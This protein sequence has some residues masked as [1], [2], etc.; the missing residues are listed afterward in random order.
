MWKKIRIS[1]LL[2]ILLVVLVNNWR[3]QNQNWNRPIVVLLHP[4]NADG[5]LSTGQYIQHLQPSQFE[6]VKTYLEQQSAA[7]RQPI[8]VI[9]KLGRSLDK[10]PPKV[11]TDPSI[12]KVMW[13]SLKFRFY[14]WQQSQSEDHSASV[15]LYLNYY[16]PHYVNELKHSTA[17]EKGR[18]GSVNLFASNKQNSQNNIVLTHEL[19][20]AFGATDKYDLH[21]GQPLYP[22]GYAS[23]EQQP[24]YPQKQAELMA[25]KIPVSDHENKMPEYLNQTIINTLTAQEIG[26]AK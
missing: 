16:D 14:A 11:P 5:Q 2:L 22:I 3:D 21:T 4:I 24:R 26:W 12:L 23:P 25:G 1:I 19:L 9:I 8:A 18:I 6:E 20:H 13:W 7:Y 17:L 10:Q 15:T